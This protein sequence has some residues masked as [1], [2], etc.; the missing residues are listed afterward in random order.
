MTAAAAAA[1][2]ERIMAAAYTE[3]PL[4]ASR[5]LKLSWKFKLGLERG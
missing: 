2:L 4:L 3:L 5:T 1:E